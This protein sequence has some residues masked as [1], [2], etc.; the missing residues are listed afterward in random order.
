M[1]KRIESMLPTY[2]Q[3]LVIILH[4]YPVN[5][6]ILSASVCLLPFADIFSLRVSCVFRGHFD[7]SNCRIIAF[8]TPGNIELVLDRKADAAAD[9]Y[10]HTQT[11]EQ[12]PP[13][14]AA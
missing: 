14:D 4:F 1:N 10:H 11:H 2:F 6:V 13:A 12:P 9:A 5:P 3:F 7:C 8:E